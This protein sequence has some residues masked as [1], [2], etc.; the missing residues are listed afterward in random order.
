MKFRETE[1][2]IETPAPATPPTPMATDAAATV[3]TIVEAFVAESVTLFDWT[4][5]LETSSAVVELRMTFV[6]TAP[7]P[8]I[9][10]PKTPP[11]PAAREAAT[12]RAV[13]EPSASSQSLPSE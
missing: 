11:K 5:S 6:A 8:L 7:A 10:P 9:A 4:I 3:A 1:A 12:T 2:P 13:I